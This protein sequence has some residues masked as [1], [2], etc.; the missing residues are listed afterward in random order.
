VHTP[1][2][3]FE[4]MPA[5][6][7]RAANQL[8][9]NFPVAVDSKRAIWQAFGVQGWPSLYFVDATGRIRSRQVGEGGYEAA[10]RLIQRLL[11]EAGRS[12]VPADLVAPQGSGTQA[13]PGSMAPASDETYVGAARARGFRS[14]DGGLRAG[15]A[16]VYVPAPA[17]GLNQWT[18]AGGWK[19]GDESAELQQPGGRIV[20]R[21][22]A[23]DLHLVLG[24][25]P[26]GPHVRFR[27]RIDGQAPGADRGSDINADG[28]GLIDSHRLYQLVRQSQA[29]RERLFEI[30]FFD[31]G[32]SAYAFT[33]G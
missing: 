7:E 21:F 22:R 3:G 17:L 26:E 2:F 18:L 25:A 11:R 15:R 5:N 10:E 32:A 16:H 27:V 9:I 14:A 23:R 24:P 28:F 8:G 1:E 31:R 20:Y 33:F 12:G 19:V 13:A 6:V 30:E 4:H 29:G